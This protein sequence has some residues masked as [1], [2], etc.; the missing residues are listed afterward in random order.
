MK[1]RGVVAAGH[2]GTAEAAVAVLQAGGNAFDAVVAAQFAGCVAEPVLASLGGGGFMVGYRAGGPSMAYD[3]FVQTPRG[4]APV[5]DLDFRPVHADF[6]TQQQAFHIGYGTVA[7][8]GLVKGLF[9]IHADL[10]TMPIAELMQP[11]IELARTGTT[12]NRFQEYMFGVVAPIV[13]HTPEARAIFES[14]EQPGK[15][16]RAGERLRME[17]LA[18][19]LDALAHEG[20]D[21]FYRGEIASAIDMASRAHHG[22]IRRAD[23][24]GYRVERRRPLQHGFGGA[25]LHIT[26]P[27]SSGGLLITFALAVLEGLELAGMQPDSADWLDLLAQVMRA[28]E[29]A[30]FES[31]A[32]DGCHLEPQRLLDPRLVARY[33]REIESRS[34][35]PHGTTHISVIDA[36]GN[37]AALSVSN[38]EGCGHVVPGSGIMLNNMLGESDLNPRGFHRWAP[39]ERLTSMMAPALLFLP[40]RRG[41]V[42]TGS[43]GSNRIRSAILQVLL[44]LLVFRQ[45]L[46]DAVAAPRIH[47]DSGLLSIEGG[48][49]Q[50]TVAEL[51]ARYPEH[52][53]WD[54]L[55]LF[56]GGA[57]TAAFDGRAFAGAGDPRREGVAVVV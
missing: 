20:A 32:A 46:E 11:A 6:G 48:F 18:D 50:A 56:F 8:P 9:E 51:A 25:V 12:M 57:H 35:A 29:G 38:G 23:L 39:N 22:H 19:T 7:T 27:P 52:R 30:R 4:R 47:Y 54:G 15:T 10:C 28:T 2:P 3:F 42:A 5:E 34:A 43:G 14:R 16:L 17:V 1:G 33:R 13:L 49:A 21:L 24:E 53:V 55:N 40:E 31:L 36:A 26:P 37:V 45:P 41:V 44:N